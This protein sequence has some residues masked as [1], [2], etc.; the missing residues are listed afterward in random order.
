[1]SQGLGCPDRVATSGLPKSWRAVGVSCGGPMARITGHPILC[2]SAGGSWAR[3]DVRASA[4]SHRKGACASSAS[5]APPGCTTGARHWQQKG[6]QP[7]ASA[8]APCCL[9]ASG[10]SAVKWGPHCSPT[11]DHAEGGARELRP[12]R[13]QSSAQPAA[14]TQRE[15]LLSTTREGGIWLENWAESEPTLWWALPAGHLLGLSPDSSPPLVLSGIHPASAAHGTEVL[16]LCMTVA[17]QLLPR[18]VS[19]F[20]AGKR[21]FQVQVC[22]F[23]YG[24]WTVLA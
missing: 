24:N 7:T 21:C 22:A 2:R 11:Q 3:V 5:L 15:G 16:E 9:C 13:A 23:V 12:W 18:A 1:M 8:Q 10:F 17:G 4:S 19:P 14:S 20:T 6:P